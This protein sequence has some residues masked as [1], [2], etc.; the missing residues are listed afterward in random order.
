MNRWCVG[1]LAWVA[2]WPPVV[3]VRA[4]VFVLTN[5]GQVRGELVNPDESPRRTYVI[6]T[7]SGQVTLDKSQVQKVVR[8]TE[9]QLAYE[10]IRGKFPDTVDAHWQLA[11]WCR[12]N[13][14]PN[15]RKAHLERIL[16]L[17]ANHAG[18]RRALGY[19][20]I[21]G[22]WV[23]QEE[24][25]AS[26]GLQRYKGRWRTPQE[27]SELQRKERIDRAEKDWTAKIKLWRGWLDDDRSREARELIRGIDNPAA[28][29]GLAQY[30]ASE[31]RPQVRTLYIEA[32][33][34]IG[35]QDA[36]HILARAAMEDRVEELRLSCLDQLKPGKHPEAV[37]VFID[38]L[39]SKENAIINR[40]AVGLAHMEDPRA[41]GPLIEVLIT[42]HKIKVSEGAPGQ[43]GAAFSP[44][45]GG[46]LSVGPKT[47]IVK[48]T[49]QNQAVLDA[50]VA[51]SGG[52]NYNFDVRAWKTWF[53][54]QKKPTTLDAR[55]D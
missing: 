41:I 8:P 7:A 48:Y 36:I 11:E 3:A 34:R 49:M 25:M 50:L 40:A 16:D 31:P 1:L 17:D 35:T 30:L 28:V 6:K 54:A 53:A 44:S 45:G 33:G 42:V 46:G 51:L 55:R 26:Q 52:A 32:L 15:E 20:Q 47:K 2:V 13:R 22:R 12:E 39:R 29:K 4:D 9:Q 27:I 5:G 38:A 43:I 14:L 21:E 10:Q 24:Y 18:A 23:T 19:S 37:A